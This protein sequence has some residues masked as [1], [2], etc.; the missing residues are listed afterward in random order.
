[1]NNQVLYTNEK[2]KRYLSTR[3]LVYSSMLTCISII[4]TRFLGIMLPIAGIP[5]L[6]ISF[7]SIPIYVTGILF[8]PIAGGLSGAIADLIGYL[9]NPMG[10]AY[11]PGFTLSA[12]IRG[13]L[14]GL[15]YLLVRY[16]K[17]KINFNII[18]A[19]TVLT[20]AGGVIKALFYK[21]VLTIKNNTVYFG[22]TTLSI[23]YIGL[24]CLVIFAYIM[25]PIVVGRFTKK[26]NEIYSIDKI[27]FVVTVCSIFVSIGLNTLW[28]SILFNKGFLIFLPTRVISSFINIPVHALILFSITR[29]FKYVK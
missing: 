5:A 3:V 28:L 14:P 8:G 10:G 22:E 12:V 2:N 19:V 29:L 27:F 13:A 6:R 25:L 21:N 26:H 20:L 11:F 17:V 18:N 7:G 9:M 16:N 15:I 1:M 4:M 24:F 23:F